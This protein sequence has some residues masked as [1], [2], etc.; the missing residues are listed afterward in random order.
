[1]VEYGLMLS[2]GFA[3]SIGSSPIP[4]FVFAFL[5]FFCG[6]LGYWMYKVPGAIV[7]ALMGLGAYLYFSNFSWPSF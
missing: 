7:G 1:M 5:S 6:V 3:F 4:I 2:K